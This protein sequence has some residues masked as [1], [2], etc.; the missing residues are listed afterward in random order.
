MTFAAYASRPPVVV[1]GA[2]LDVKARL[3]APPV[4]GT[5]NPGSVRLAPGGVAR[6]IA[7]ALAVLG[8][9]ARLI[10]AVGDDAP[11][12]ILLR[13]CAE[14]GVDTRLVRRVS[15][16]TGVYAA[17]LAEAGDLMIGVSDM[18]ATE[19]LGPGDIAD[20]AA[21]LRNAGC[22]IAD[23]NLRTDTLR[24][25]GR[26]CAAASL[27]FVIEPVS[28]AKA[29]RIEAVLAEGL[30]IALLT[31]NRDELAA[32]VPPSA[33]VADRADALRSRGV[34]RVIVHAGADG[35]IAVDGHG[36]VAVAAEAGPV[37][38]VTGSGDVA[39][40]AALWGLRRGATLAEAAGLGQRAA[41]LARASD[42]AVPP[43]LTP[44]ALLPGD[45]A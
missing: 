12:T 17:T 4:H 37:R 44:S 21:E 43:G 9:P 7:H 33:S 38:D 13:H 15:A 30:P 24:A 20:A 40:A 27:P 19:A 2:N 5:S 45:C 26:L 6:N 42:S 28:V 8:E 14:G 35:A 11:G 39:L 18:A 41:A 32:L 29:A 1:G 23:A 10:A 16:P 31:P 25:L 3:L 34:A 22:I 36:S